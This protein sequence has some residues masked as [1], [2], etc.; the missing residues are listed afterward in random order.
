M[1]FLLTGAEL[2]KIIPQAIAVVDSLDPRNLQKQKEDI[3]KKLS[4]PDIWDSPSLA[5]ELNKKLTDLQVKLEKVNIIKEEAQN[6]KIALELEDLESLEMAIDNIQTTKNFLEN[7][8]F[9]Q[10]KFDSKDCI[11]Y[12][13]AGAGGVDAQDFAAMLASMYQA[14]CKKEG[15]KVSIISL[16]SGSEGGVKSM[17][18]EVSGENAFGLLKEE[19]GIHR[20]VRISPFNSGN[21]R[22]TSFAAV[23]VLPVGLGDQIK[24]FRIDEKDLKWDYFMS[25][26]KGG[27]S[28][29]TTY[30]AVRVTHTPTGIST[31]CQNERNQI[32]NKVVALDH[33]KDRLIAI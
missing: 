30:S 20:L 11:L 24:D 6:S 1:D 32:Q 7:Q 26:G 22:E 2:D 28:V 16:S 10:G 13:Q 21:T 31:T 23:S 17:S 25:S 29:N 3:E 8:L 14:F 5:G 18:L 15:F 4:D 9:L 12:F 19:A 27:Q 33:L